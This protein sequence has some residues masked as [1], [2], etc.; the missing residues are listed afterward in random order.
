MGDTITTATLNPH[1]AHAPPRPLTLWWESFCTQEG[2]FPDALLIIVVYKWD[3]DDAAAVP[4]S[5]CN[6]LFTLLH[7]VAPPDKQH[8]LSSPR[9]R[10]VRVRVIFCERV[11]AFV[12]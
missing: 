6:A 9:E 4:S 5:F 12:I 2:Q 8:I 1:P 10:G 7:F 3:K 11:D